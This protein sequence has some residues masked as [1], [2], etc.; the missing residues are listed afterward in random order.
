M[1]EEDDTGLIHMSSDE[2]ATMNGDMC[3]RKSE[4]IQPNYDCLWGRL[5]EHI[6]ISSNIK[7]K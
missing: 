2:E 7:T 3:K 4:A 5:D 6:Q 1:I